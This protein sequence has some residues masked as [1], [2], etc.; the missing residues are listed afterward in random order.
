MVTQSEGALC[1]SPLRPE[2]FPL[3]PQCPQQLWI[4]E[5][6]PSLPEIRPAKSRLFLSLQFRTDPHLAPPR[7]LYFTEGTGPWHQ[8]AANIRAALDASSGLG[9]AGRPLSIPQ[10][11]CGAPARRLSQKGERKITRYAAHGAISSPLSF[12]LEIFF[13]TLAVSGSCHPW[14]P[15]L[16]SSPRALD[17]DYG[18]LACQCR[19]PR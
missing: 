17:E 10:S 13:H 3:W 5:S 12:A 11:F 7:Y 1:A 6:F 9:E 19:R 8:R 2:F 18:R 16:P 15:G 4:L 14:T